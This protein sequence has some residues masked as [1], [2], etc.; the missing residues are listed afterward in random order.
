VDDVTYWYQ[1]GAGEWTEVASQSIIDNLQYDN[2]TGTLA[3]LA[4]ARY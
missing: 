3:T 4:N 1:N 2:G